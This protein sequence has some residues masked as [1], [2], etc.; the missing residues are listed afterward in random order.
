M[1]LLRH[2]LRASSSSSSGI[3]TPEKWVEDWFSGGVGS[4]AGVAVS[5]ETALHYSP[6]FAGVNALSTDVGKLPLPLYE[7]LDRGKRK[8][9][10]HRLYRVLHD[11]PNPAQS[12][13]VAR[14]TVQGHTLGW[15]TGYFNLVFDGRGNVKEMW[16]LRPDR[17]K[18]E[19]VYDRNVAG[20][21]HVN[22]L[23][24]DPVNGIRTRLFPDEVLV[25]GGL[26]YDGVRGYSLVQ[27][28]RNSLGLGMAAERYG[29][30]LFKNGSRPGG[31]ISHPKSLSEGAQKRIRAN[32]ENLHRGLDRAQRMAIFE[33]GMRWEEVGIPPE[34]AQF[35]ETRELQVEEAC[36]WLRIPPHKV[37][38][39]RRAT[40]TNIE[41]QGLEYVT[42]SLQGWLVTWEQA[43]WQRCL[44][45]PDKDRYFAEHTTDALTRGDIE[46][47]YKAHAIGRVN[48]FLSGDDIAEIENRN[49]LPNGVG[50][51]YWM[52]LNMQPALG[53]GERAQ[54]RACPVHPGCNCSNGKAD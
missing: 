42:D 13:L 9:R 31:Y 49:P 16:P 10:E 30:A 41:H 7:R 17:M 14:R 1:G 34:D 40:F 27:M 32:Y 51:T 38:S 50:E 11:E 35:L 22:W 18:P 15:G 5:E 44:V 3:A 46:T 43:I 39:L 29:S 45:G 37:A 53:P 52:P 23:Y 33:E 12:P 24:N 20:K 28:A 19:K 4:D 2:A 26:G 6:F 54:E 48:G 47:R 25:I 21:F 36:R 8:A